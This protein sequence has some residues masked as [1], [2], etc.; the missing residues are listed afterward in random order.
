MRADFPS[1]E[2]E[3]AYAAVLDRY[4]ATLDPSVRATLT[5][6]EAIEEHRILFG[7]PNAPKPGGL[8][9]ATD[10]VPEEVKR[11][12]SSC[13]RDVRETMLRRPDLYPKTLAL[14]GLRWTGKRFECEEI[15][16]G[17]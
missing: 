4:A 11:R 8:L 7:D 3:R 6:Y 10:S 14:F 12:L 13:K 9:V 16:R 17:K 2:R 15:S 5:T 1:T